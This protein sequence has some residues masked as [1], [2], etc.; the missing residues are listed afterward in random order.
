MTTTLQSDVSRQKVLEDWRGRR[1]FSMFPFNVKQLVVLT[2]LTKKSEHAVDYAVSLAQYFQ[3]GLTLLHVC[4]PLTVRESYFDVPSIDV[5]RDL[6]RL[7]TAIGLKHTPCRACLRCGRYREE[8]FKIAE[9][10]S[11][12]LL[13]VSENN[14]SWFRSFIQ[15]DYNGKFILDAPC[16]VVVISHRETTAP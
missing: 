12:D 16:P 6:L 10:R 11:A 1:S 3:A 5:E 15:E 4:A 2:D 7:A 8:A 13:V 14:L 9:E